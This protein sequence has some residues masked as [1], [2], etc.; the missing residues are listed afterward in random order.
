MAD[1]ITTVEAALTRAL[2]PLH[3]ALQDG[4]TVP[5]IGVAFSGGIDSTALLQSAA[6]LHRRGSIAVFAFHIHHG[7]AAAADDW[8]VHCRDQSAAFGVAFDAEHVVLAA[9]GSSIEAQARTLRYAALA[10]LCRRHDCTVLLTAHHA[11]DQAEAVLLNLARGAGI[12]GLAA[13]ARSRRMEEIL[14]L[15]PLIDLPA[16]VLRTAVIDAGLSFVDDPSNQDR[17]YTRNAIRHEVMPALRRIVP[18][19]ATR[20]AQ[21]ATHASTMQGLL[22]DIGLEDLRSPDTNDDEL[23]VER[24]GSL[25][26]ARAANALRVWIA[27]RGM[28]APTAAALKEMLDQLLHASSDAQIALLHERHTL[29]LYRG[30]VSVDASGAPHAG[31]VSLAWRGEAE[32]T[33]PAWH[34]SLVFTTTDGPGFAPDALR[35]GPLV[36]RERSGGERLRMRTGGP[37]RTLKN[38]YQEAGV[39]MWRRARLPLVY[40]GDRLIYAAGI[41]ANA[42][43]L[44]AGGEG[45]A[46]IAI[47]WRPDD[48]Q[49]A[50]M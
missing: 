12:G 39:A 4:K 48:E 45:T 16:A 7:L 9:T 30:R 37:S 5:R 35:A 24:L 1:A 38:L 14:L 33:V 17:R 20:L 44:H 25:S 2:G 29:R 40:L 36:L 22:D 15:R 41:G 19:I 23:D 31:F 49:R 3:D 42:D 32:L 46:L 13:T 8:L 34:G 6:A 18:T 50:R 27:R 47:D 10:R 11:D 21:T 28:R 43:C 26:E